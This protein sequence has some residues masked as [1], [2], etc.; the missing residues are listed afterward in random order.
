MKEPPSPASCGIHVFPPSVVLWTVPA[1]LTTQPVVLFTNDSPVRSFVVPLL[2]PPHVA[3]PFDVRR[4][5]PPF[6]TAHPRDVLTNWTRCSPA[7]VLWCVQ[8]VPASVVPQTPPSPTVQPRLVSAKKTPRSVPTGGD[9][10]GPPPPLPPPVVAGRTAID[11]GI[12]DADVPPPSV[13]TERR[14]CGP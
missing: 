11:T 6:P 3:P 7:D 8:V 4:I 10:S 12:D 14:L 2:S 13:A 9:E 1:A 5:V